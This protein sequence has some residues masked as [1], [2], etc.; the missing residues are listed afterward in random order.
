[1][2]MDHILIHIASIH[3]VPM[4]IIFE[5]L[6]LK[7]K[8][9]CSKPSMELVTF[10]DILSNEYIPSLSRYSNNAFK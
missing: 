3:D 2:Q 7:K 8:K 6:S 10:C 1:M 5:A 4:K 9:H